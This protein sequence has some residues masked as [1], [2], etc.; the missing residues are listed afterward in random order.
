MR[1]DS[2]DFEW[3]VI[4]LTLE[5]VGGCE[6]VPLKLGKRKPGHWIAPQ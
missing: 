1:Y 2:T 6:E 3:S 4:H 5:D